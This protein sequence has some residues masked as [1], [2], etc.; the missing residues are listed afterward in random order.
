MGRIA[1]GTQKLM[2][3]TG[4]PGTGKTAILNRL[5]A[6]VSAVAEPAREILAEQ[7]AVGGEGTPDR[8]AGLFVR[9]LLRRSI[10]TY[11]AALRS[12]SPTLFDRGIPDCV[13][14][15]VILGVDPTS[16]ARA[17]DR[18]RYRDEV[19]SLEP[20]EEIYTTDEERTMSFDDTLL[21]HAAL[22]E[23]YDDAGYGLISVPKRPV[24]DRAAFVRDSIR[25]RD[26]G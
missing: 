5:S 21:F 26:H 20:W 3:L 14:Y 18:Y 23:T 15:A 6:E 19:F 13:A 25:A 17:V 9:L 2:I 16:A 22:V 10:D 24:S 11:E 4:A 12:G 7:R 1:S 8:D